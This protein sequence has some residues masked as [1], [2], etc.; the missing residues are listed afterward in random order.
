L[1]EFSAAPEQRSWRGQ[2]GYFLGIGIGPRVHRV[3]LGPV[4]ALSQAVTDSLRST[5]WLIQFLQRLFTGQISMSNV[6]GPI[7][8]TVLSGRQA[9]FGWMALAGFMAMISI[10]L[11]VL[12]LLPIPILDGG[13]LVFLAIEGLRRR[14]LSQR[15]KERVTQVGFML[16]LLLFAVVMYNDVMRYFFR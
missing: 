15:V 13:H 5:G 8:I 3:R 7:G 14:D 6:A 12:N 1:L 16:L 11:A 2:T 4:A 10:N 9:Q